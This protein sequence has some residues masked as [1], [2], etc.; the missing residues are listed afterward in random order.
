[1]TVQKGKKSEINK[2]MT[3]HSCEKQG[4]IIWTKWSMKVL[5]NM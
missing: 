5:L 4:N 3:E 2:M 1:M